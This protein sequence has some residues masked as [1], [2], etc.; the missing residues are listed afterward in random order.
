MIIETIIC[1][2][3]SQGNVNFAPFG[4]KKNKNYILISPYIPSTTLNN[5]RATGNAS[6]NYTDDA[7]FFV[8]C[9]T[10]VLHSLYTILDF[11]IFLHIKMWA[12]LGRHFGDSWAAFVCHLGQIW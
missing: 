8:N 5:L 6:I 4:I 9:F 12:L 10:H 1:T 11:Y 2:K 3:N 7:T